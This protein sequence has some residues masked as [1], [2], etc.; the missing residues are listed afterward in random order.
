M[1]ADFYIDDIPCIDPKGLWGSLTIH[2]WP[3]NNHCSCNGVY[4]Y[5]GERPSEAHLLVPKSFVD[6][7]DQS[8]AKTIRINHDDGV[9]SLPGW[10]VYKCEAAGLGNNTD[11][12]QIFYLQLRDARQ[13]ALLSCF[14]DSSGLTGTM[15]SIQNSGEAQ[16]VGMDW[17]DVLSFIWGYFPEAAKLSGIPTL[18]ATPDSV[19]ENLTFEAL[20]C[21]VALC[22]ALNACGHFAVVDPV[23]QDYAF[24]EWNSTQS[25]L[26]ALY[27]A[28][29]LYLMWDGYH[30]SANATNYPDKIRIV[31]PPDRNPYLN[32]TTW[33][34]PSVENVSTG[35]SGV[36]ADTAWVLID[37]T[38]SEKDEE[39]TI[40]NQTQ[41]DNR[42]ADLAKYIKGMFDAA[43]NPTCRVYSK[44]IPDFRC[45]SEVSEV[46]WVNDRCGVYTKVIKSG[47]PK[48]VLP[49]NIPQ[50]F[51][52]NYPL[53]AVVGYTLT[54]AP[55]RSGTTLGSGTANIQKISSGE[56]SDL[57]GDY[58]YLTNVS[59][60]NLSTSDV[61]VGYVF[62][63]REK[64]TGQYIVIWEDCG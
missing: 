32:I 43:A 16:E 55:G 51:V 28:N 11:D 24:R 13:I 41:M 10:Y 58:G 29:S 46:A 40:V 42:K 45:G 9:L 64:A 18:D 19:A 35:V 2:N 60:Y 17:Q 7:M 36:T 44:V 56:L 47:E 59:F 63:Q 4:C 57:T 33:R 25:G 27:S 30:A 52:S 20:P 23:D 50:M 21:W 26:S 38:R 15:R 8:T 5:R 6:D 39:G 3:L 34:E 22:Q 31:F 14:E 48:L 49:S 12:N 37:T 53:D 54:G 62:L 1:F 61:A